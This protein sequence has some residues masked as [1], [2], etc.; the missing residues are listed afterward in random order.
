M[1]GSQSQASKRREQLIREGKLPP[2]T[3]ASV[4]VA[5][6]LLGAVRRGLVPAQV[7]DAKFQG[8]VLELQQAR[9]AA[10]LGLIEGVDYALRLV[11]GTEKN[12]PHA[13]R[14]NA[15]RWIGEVAGLKAGEE[16]G[17]GDAPL[18]EVAAAVL[19]EALAQLTREVGKRD[20]EDAEPI[21]PP[22]PDQQSAAPPAE[23]NT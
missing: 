3:K 16:G 4:H 20:A 15:A 18:N 11:R 21:E 10:R 9:A 8:I 13:V 23:S 12:A 17:A 6:G 5:T 22:A 2:P 19:N 14:L 7:V 1:R